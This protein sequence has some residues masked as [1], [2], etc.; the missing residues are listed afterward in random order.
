MWSSSSI[1]KESGDGQDAG[2][3]LQPPIHREVETGR[4][5]RAGCVPEGAEDSKTWSSGS[6]CIPREL[7]TGSMRGSGS[8]PKDGAARKALSLKLSLPSSARGM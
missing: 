1:P 5:W 8:I 3:H 6:G 2:P 7:R 4:M